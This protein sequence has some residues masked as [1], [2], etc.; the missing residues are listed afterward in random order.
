VDEPQAIQQPSDLTPAPDVL[1]PRSRILGRHQAVRDGL[2][3]LRS[4]SS[5][6]V[7]GRAGPRPIVVAAPGAPWGSRCCPYPGSSGSL[8]CPAS[9]PGLLWLQAQ[10]S[11]S[12]DLFG[13]PFGHHL[14]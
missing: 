10:L 9:R 2:E 6:F 4:A 12:R 14:P 1:S 8:A 3:A 11:S 5:K 7:Y 13:L